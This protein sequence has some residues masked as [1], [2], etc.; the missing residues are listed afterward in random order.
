MIV[1][2]TSQL[3]RSLQRELDHFFRLVHNTEFERRCL[4][5]GALTQARAK[6]KHTAF[7]ELD[8]EV[9]DQFY[10][11]KSIKKWRTHRL[12]AMDGSTITLPRSEELK[13]S[14]G[15]HEFGAD[16]QKRVLA[17]ISH[18]YD[19]LNKVIID[20]QI[21]GYSVG[22]IHLAHRHLDKIQAQD[23][24]IADRYYGSKPL[25][26]LLVSRGAD[27]CF[28]LKVHCWKE[29]KLLAESTV[30]NERLVKFRI[31]E[32][33]AESNRLP[34]NE[35]TCRLIRIPLKSGEVEILCTSLIDT[36]K[37]PTDEFKNLYHQRWGIEEYY[38]TLK[39]HLEIENFSGKTYLSIL[40]DFYIKIFISICKQLLFIKNI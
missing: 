12:L 29:A 4:T 24:I 18:L 3:T 38:K 17:R 6:L 37:Y 40:Q 32:K 28:R 10:N 19:P 15:A 27:F 13:K 14:F 7:I 26:M 5:K 21:D 33:E 8:K 1:F 23:L 2:L 22:E 25:F 34:I 20:G 30:E 9:K 16:R 31:S 11:Q 36:Q 39:H 35:L